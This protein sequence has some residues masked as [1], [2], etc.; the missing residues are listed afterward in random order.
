MIAA[1][2]EAD[3]I[4]QVLTHHIRQGLQ[5]VMIDN[6]STDGTYDIARPFVGQGVVELKRMDTDYYDWRL[7]LSKLSEM[8]ARLKPDWAVLIGADEFLEDPN[9]ATGETLVE[10][11]QNEART[12]YDV[13]Q[14]DSFEFWP[15]PKDDSRECDVRR[16]MKY[17]TWSNSFN[18]RA[19]RCIAG[20]TITESGGHY[21]TP[22][23]GITLRISPRKFVLRHY[24]FRS[25]QHG[26]R[27]VFR[28]RLPRLRNQ[29]QGWN[30]HYDSFLPTEH[31]FVRDPSELTLYSEDG[32]WQMMRKFDTT[33]GKLVYPPDDWT[34][35][36]LIR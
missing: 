18:F 23:P 15:T 24:K 8:A 10:G 17:Y 31:F 13:I 12:G 11:I 21:P 3:V 28:E 26:V 2:N 9:A 20:A 33:F 7:L 22:L 6:G 36:G 27:K 29:P 19:Y 5:L 1:Y 34:P 14:F 4:D 16:R 25:Y 35:P 30:V 32:K